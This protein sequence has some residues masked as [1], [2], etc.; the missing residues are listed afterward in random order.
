MA[1]ADTILA[2]AAGNV[3]AAF[4]PYYP[5]SAIITDYAANTLPT[6]TLLICFAAGCAAILTPTL[7]LIRR[8][9]PSLSNG[10]V[11][12]AMWFVLCGFIH[13]FFEGEF[14]VLQNLQSR[15]MHRPN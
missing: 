10:E 13:F 8:T 12:T 4:H 15:E 9:N 7:I 14:F 11:A 2:N 6:L 1:H 3:S 5:P